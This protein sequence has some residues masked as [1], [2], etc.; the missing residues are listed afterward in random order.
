[1]PDSAFGIERFHMGFRVT[2]MDLDSSNTPL[3]SSKWQHVISTLYACIISIAF[4]DKGCYGSQASPNPATGQSTKSLLECGRST[5]L[6]PSALWRGGRRWG[7]RH[8]LPDSTW[9][10]WIPSP[11]ATEMITAGFFAGL[12]FL[13]RQVRLRVDYIQSTRSLTGRKILLAPGMGGEKAPGSMVP[14]CRRTRGRG[15]RM[16]QV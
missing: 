5:P 9:V 2:N 11:R 10:L 14:H 1:M 3:C 7:E 8:T 15:A 16:F 13:G 6:M 12:Y 4:F